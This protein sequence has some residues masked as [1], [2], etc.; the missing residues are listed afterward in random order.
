VHRYAGLLAAAGDHLVDAVGA[1][2]LAVSGPEPQLR[3]CGQRVAGAGAEVAVH[4]D[5]GVVAELD[6]AVLAALAV[7]GDLPLPQV[8]VA[9]V[10]VVSAVADA[11][12]FRQAD[13]R[14][15]EHRDD[16]GAKDRP[17]Q[18]FSRAA[19]S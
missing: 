17:A 1:Q 13:A 18:A 15:G 4:A 11:G 3:P 10:R 5:G 2:R 19:N 7:D 8:D 9:A 16:R 6:D 12:Q 14:R